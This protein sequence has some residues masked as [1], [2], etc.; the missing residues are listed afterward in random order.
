[1]ILIHPEAFNSLA[2]LVHCGGDKFENHFKRM[3]VVECFFFHIFR[4]VA[5]FLYV[6]PFMC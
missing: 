6:K 4:Y 2:W 5:Y 3:Y 1:M